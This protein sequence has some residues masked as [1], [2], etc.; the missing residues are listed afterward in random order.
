MTKFP[1]NYLI[2]PPSL[3]LLFIIPDHP[4]WKPS[5]ALV[6]T[7]A[8]AAFMLAVKPTAG[9]RCRAVAQLGNDESHAPRHTHIGDKG[10]QTVIRSGDTSLRGAQVIGKGIRADSRN[11]SQSVHGNCNRHRRLFR[12]PKLK[13]INV[14]TVKKTTGKK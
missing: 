4:V 10:S 2:P 1:M 13:S 8:T 14:W 11:P 9:F 6:I 3:L 7:V 12:Q 5:R